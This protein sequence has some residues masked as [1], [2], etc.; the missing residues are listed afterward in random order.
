MICFLRVLF[1][2]FLLFL[3][4]CRETCVLILLDPDLTLDGLIE[5]YQSLSLLY[6]RD[7]LDCVQEHLHE[8]VMVET[9]DLYKKIVL[10]GY[11]MTLDY[12]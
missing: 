10:S 4:A 6:I 12:F 5:G 3:D 11:E 8:V 9:I 2:L 1:C 7:L